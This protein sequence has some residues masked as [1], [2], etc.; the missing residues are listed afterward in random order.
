MGRGEY[1]KRIRKSIIILLVIN[2]IFFGIFGFWMWYE[3]Q[4]TSGWG[5]GLSGILFFPCYFVFAI[6]YGIYSYKATRMILLP[7]VMLSVFGTACFAF[8]SIAEKGYSYNYDFFLKVIYSLISSPFIIV[9]LTSSLIT[10]LIIDKKEK[11]NE[12]QED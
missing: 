3:I 6:G 11:A 12:K 9:C 4:N 8:M 7:I 5:M 10:K 2:S 1:Q